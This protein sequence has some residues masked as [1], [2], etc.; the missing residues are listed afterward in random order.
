MVGLGG[1]PAAA[2][3]GPVTSGVA[4]RRWWECGMRAG[5]GGKRSGG[6][7]ARP[8]GAAGTRAGDRAAPAMAAAAAAHVCWRL[9]EVRWESVRFGEI[10][11]VDG[12]I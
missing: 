11:N 4:A 9:G 3:D 1:G 12:L 7:T 5:V 2:G 8:S 6:A 10:G